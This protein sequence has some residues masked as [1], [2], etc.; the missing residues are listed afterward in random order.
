MATIFD[1]STYFLEC[2]TNL[3]DIKHTTNT[4][5]FHRVETLQTMDEFLAQGKNLSGMNLVVLDKISGRLD[6]SSKSDNLIDRRFF[7]FFLLKLA[8]HGNY[9]L[10]EQVKQDCNTSGRKIMS[11]MF[12][13][14][15]E[16]INGL[17]D[18]NKSSIYYDTVGPISHGYYGVMVTFSLYNPAGI[19]YNENDWN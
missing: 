9:N 18:L 19:I 12:K 16:S 15:N 7:T 4:P 8:D 14:K 10:I 11:K 5:R 13:D 17:K 1:F 2:A 3:K 6:D